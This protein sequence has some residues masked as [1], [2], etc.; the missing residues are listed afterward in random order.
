MADDEISEARRIPRDQK[1]SQPFLH[2]AQAVQAR[3]ANGNVFYLLLTYLECGSRAANAARNPSGRKLCPFSLPP[4]PDNCRG[5]NNCALLAD[6]R[7]A[8]GCVVE[9]SHASITA[10]L[11]T[12]LKLYLISKT[13]G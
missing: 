10:L 2:H 1:V 5:A 7:K 8:N 6:D 3:Q 4:K 12:S 9:W 13:V 11:C